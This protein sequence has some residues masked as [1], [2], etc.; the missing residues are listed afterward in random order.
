MGRHKMISGWHAKFLMSL[1]RP[2]IDIKCHILRFINYG[3]WGREMNDAAPLG[4]L[5]NDRWCCFSSL[6]LC[7][8]ERQRQTKSNATFANYLRV[9][10]DY[11]SSRV[12][13][14]HFSAI[15]EFIIYYSFRSYRFCE[16]D[17]GWMTG[18]LWEHEMARST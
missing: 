8:R 13:L 5:K 2:H 9:R 16:G 11:I 15:T 12:K 7:A 14:G 10:R 17:E 1:L 18:G 6:D 4:A 3:A